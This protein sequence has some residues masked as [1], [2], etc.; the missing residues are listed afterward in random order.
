[1][2]SD[3]SDRLARAYVHLRALRDNIPDYR[4]IEEVYVK[5]Y[6]EALGRLEEIG[7]DVAE[8]KVSQGH[9]KS[10]TIGSGRQTLYIDRPLLLSKMDA[11]LTYFDLATQ[12]ADVRIGFK[13]PR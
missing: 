2:L 6:H 10:R 12:Q 13:P 9:L 8:F 11:V 1:M 3:Q 5:Q 7:Y 4:W